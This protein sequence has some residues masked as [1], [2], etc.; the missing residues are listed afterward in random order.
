MNPV[1][2]DLCDRPREW[3]YGSYPAH[4]AGE[5]P[6]PHLTTAYTR[7]LYAG[8]TS[9]F[10]A[11]VD[12]AV[13]LHRGGKPALAAILPILDRLTP[14]H[15]RHVREVYGFTVPEIATHY[16]RSPRHVAAMIRSRG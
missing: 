11:S 16:R 1:R 9:T 4:A 15:V 10:A 5:P 2:A 3:E 14:E 12:A 7:A 6:R 8:R 13:A